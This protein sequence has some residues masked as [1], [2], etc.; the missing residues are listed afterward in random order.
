[1]DFNRLNECRLLVSHDVNIHIKDNEGKNA[2]FYAVDYGW[3]GWEE[4]IT[5]V[6]D[7]GIDPD[8][9]D[10]LGKTSLIEIIASDN[11]YREKIVELLVSYGA[12]VKMQRN[13]GWSALTMKKIN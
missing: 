12:N 8:S 13:D 11:Y 9:Q 4:L 6:L 7:L 10:N 1:M 3:K 2:L 5:Y